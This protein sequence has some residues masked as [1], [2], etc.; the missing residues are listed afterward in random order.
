MIEIIGEIDGIGYWI[1]SDLYADSADCIGI[2]NGASGLITRDGYAKPACYAFNFLS[3]LGKKLILRGNHYL[4]SRTGK[5]RYEMVCH[6][7]IK[8]DYQYYLNEE[9]EI[10]PEQLRS[11]YSSEGRLTLN[12]RFCEIEDG[13][14]VLRMYRVN[15]NSGSIQDEWI[16]LGCEEN[17]SRDEIRYIKQ[18]SSPSLYKKKYE[19][20]GNDLE[21]DI[22]MEPQEIALIQIER[23]S[24]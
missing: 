1:L 18:K 4:I 23:I 7:Y 21:F 22:Q 8:L 6:N 14:Y 20:H 11:F 19:V 5:N 2:I 16:R 3:N 13:E 24:K 12:F 15:E 10:R 17:L 9:Y